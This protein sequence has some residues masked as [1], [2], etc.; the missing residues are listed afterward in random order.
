MAS[1]VQTISHDA[2]LEHSNAHDARSEENDASRETPAGES[3]DGGAQEENSSGAPKQ[4]RAAPVKED[5]KAIGTRM[6]ELLMEKTK[7]PIAEAYTHMRNQN[8]RLAIGKS[9]E[10]SIIVL[11]REAGGK[12]TSTSASNSAKKMLIEAYTDLAEIDDDIKIK[13]K[14]AGESSKA[15]SKRKAAPGG[16][17]RAPAKKRKASKAEKGKGPAASESSSGPVSREELQEKLDMFAKS[18]ARMTTGK[19]AM[20]QVVEDDAERKAIKEA[21]ELRKK[22]FEQIKNDIIEMVT[23]N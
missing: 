15:A 12:S 3:D 2:N 9:S 20:K 7:M 17:D 1:P 13:R 4:R 19:Y 22:E 23:C 5:R 14:E 10:L 18:V 6:G 21:F 16:S 8:M 11:Y